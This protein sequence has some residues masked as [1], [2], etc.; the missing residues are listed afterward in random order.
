M[1]S[2]SAPSCNQHGNIHKPSRKGRKASHAGDLHQ[3]FLV[4]REGGSSMYSHMAQKNY[5]NLL[6]NDVIWCKAGGC[7]VLRQL[8]LTHY[9]T[10]LVQ[11]R[12]II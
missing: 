3:S 2:E 10:A 5:N 1:H 4:T 12:N 6:S 8:K 9:Q 11:L 7:M